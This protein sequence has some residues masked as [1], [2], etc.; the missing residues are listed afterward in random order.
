MLL[1]NASLSPSTLAS[2]PL[3]PPPNMP[4]DGSSGLMLPS[5]WILS[6]DT[7]LTGPFSTMGRTVELD[8]GNST[9]PLFAA[10]PYLNTSRS[11]V[12]NSSSNS[13]SSSNGSAMEKDHPRPTVLLSLLVLT[14]LGPASLSA[15]NLTDNASHQPAE[16][17]QSA[18]PLWAL[19]PASAQEGY[20]SPCDDWER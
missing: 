2:L 6:G 4:R 3:A 20:P 13:S 18:L 19:R 10:L 11:D 9:Q 15:W 1:G 8:L 12:G 7:W 14:G 5:P 16:V 17:V